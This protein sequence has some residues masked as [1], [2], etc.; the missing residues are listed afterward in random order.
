MV[1]LG[2]VATAI[3][4]KRGDPGGIPLEHGFFTFM[5]ALQ[6]GG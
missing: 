2:G 6:V 5:E 3:T 4:A 1:G